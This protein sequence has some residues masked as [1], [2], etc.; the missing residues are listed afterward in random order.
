VDRFRSPSRLTPAA[1]TARLFPRRSP[2]RLLTA[3]ARGGLQ[4][5]PA[6]RPRRATRPPAQLLHLRH[7]SA[8]SWSDLLHRASFSVRGT[9][10]IEHRLFSYISINWRA[11]PLVSYQAVIDLIGATT[12]TT[13]LKVYARLDTSTYPTKIKITDEQIGTVRLT[14]EDFHP[15][16]N[17]RILPTLISE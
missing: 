6:G 13:G 5:S 2:P 3:A 1:L 9:H 10:K 17:Y 14:G 15:E 4:P 16:W 12:T 11:K 7:S 8:I